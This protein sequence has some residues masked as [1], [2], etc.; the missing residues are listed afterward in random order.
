MKLLTAFISGTLFGL[1]LIL[2]GMTD[3]LKVLAFL[4]VTGRW[5][6]SL[7]LVMVG[8][9]GSAA[10]G[11]AYAGKRRHTLLGD[12]LQLP[13]RRDINTPLIVGSTLFGIGWGFF[14]CNNMPIL[15]Q[16]APVNL[17]ATGYGLFNLAGC[18]VGG[19][20]AA[21]AG[22]LKSAI[23]LGGALQV[24]AVLLLVAA[25]VLWRVQ[26]QAQANVLAATA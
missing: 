23:G 25:V 9:I 7:A 13:E 5:D 4:D 24:S 19:T 10:M 12:K 14:D 8:A 17:R 20:M 26:P 1:G 18:I 2:A 22:V 6:P 11:F 16:I 21:L 3:P 15:C